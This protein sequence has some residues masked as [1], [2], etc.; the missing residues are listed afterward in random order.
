MGLQLK[1]LG[2]GKAPSLEDKSHP[3]LSEVQLPEST[4]KRAG[5]LRKEE[6]TSGGCT[7]TSTLQR[8]HDQQGPGHMG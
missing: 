1:G 5:N 4:S 2:F 6:G 7:A 3:H 8:P